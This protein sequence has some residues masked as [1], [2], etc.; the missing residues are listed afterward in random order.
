[1]AHSTRNGGVELV[2]DCSVGA[3]AQSRKAATSVRIQGSVRLAM[4]PMATYTTGTP[5]STLS[6]SQLCNGGLSVDECARHVLGMGPTMWAYGGQYSGH[7]HAQLLSYRMSRPCQ[8]AMPEVLIGAPSFAFIAC[9]RASGARPYHICC[10][11][12]PKALC[13]RCHTGWCCQWCEYVV[14]DDGVSVCQAGVYSSIGV[15]QCAMTAGSCSTVAT[16]RQWSANVSHS[17]TSG[18]SRSAASSRA[19]CSGG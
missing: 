1:M 16:S 5:A 19:R 15:L 4:P 11:S 18:L 7:S 10:S 13:S 9:I 14:S 2:V 8:L 3:A 17:S 12:T 6:S